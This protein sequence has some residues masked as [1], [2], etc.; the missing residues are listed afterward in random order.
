MI[1]KDIYPLYKEIWSLAKIQE[2]SNNESIIGVVFMFIISLILLYLGISI[3]GWILLLLSIYLVNYHFIKKRQFLK[4]V[5]K[6]RP[7]E[8]SHNY[9]YE[10]IEHILEIVGKLYLVIQSNTNL[11]EKAGV[12]RFWNGYRKVSWINTEQEAFLKYIT[13]TSALLEFYKKLEEY[14]YLLLINVRSELK[15]NILEQEV[16]LDIAKSDIVKNLTG[17]PDLVKV[18]E[19]QQ[20]RLDSQIEEFEKLQKILVKV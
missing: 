7:M 15:K 10:N 9:T 4:E 3:I 16:I 20:A 19:L 14:C 5:I 18:S 1:K 13:G 2:K 12:R 6:L 8:L 17:T 11:D